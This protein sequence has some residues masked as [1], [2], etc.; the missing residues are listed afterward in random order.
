MRHL[1][2]GYVFA[3]LG[4]AGHRA[5]YPLVYKKLHALRR[6]FAFLMGGLVCTAL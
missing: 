3:T 4:G 1:V 5:T 2:D 6:Q